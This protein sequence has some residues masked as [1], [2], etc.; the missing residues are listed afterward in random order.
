[1]AKPFLRTLS[2]CMRVLF[3]ALLIG[4]VLPR[5]PL[6]RAQQDNVRRGPSVYENRARTEKTTR[7][8]YRRLEVASAVL[9]IA[10][11]GVTILLMG[12]RR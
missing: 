2:R 5:D 12:R 11:G 6:A 7:S 8:R 4:Q 3:L 1:M 9:I 10:A